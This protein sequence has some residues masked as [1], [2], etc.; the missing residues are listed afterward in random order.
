MRQNTLQ[1]LTCKQTLIIILVT[2]GGAPRETEA[3]PVRYLREGLLVGGLAQ[4]THGGRTRR[5][6]QGHLQVSALRRRLHRR[7]AASGNRLVQL[8]RLWVCFVVLGIRF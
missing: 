7:D 6:R 4:Q 1:D 8:Y 2:S 3:A 5:G